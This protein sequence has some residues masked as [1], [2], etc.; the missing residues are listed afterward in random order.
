MTIFLSEGQH[1]W[2]T[3][4]TL[5]HRCM[6]T[7]D[8]KLTPPSSVSLLKTFEAENTTEITK[9]VLVFSITSTKCVTYVI[10]DISLITDCPRFGR[11][12]EFK[13]NLNWL[14]AL[15]PFMGKHIKYRYTSQYSV[16]SGLRPQK[17]VDRLH[18]KRGSSMAS[19]F[20]HN[21]CQVNFAHF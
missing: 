12:L 4:I 19:F 2:L 17:I 3:A 7:N 10:N 20:L 9:R 6:F 13:T 5:L 11:W 8:E 16:T 14:A 1:F 21:L 15:R 18:K